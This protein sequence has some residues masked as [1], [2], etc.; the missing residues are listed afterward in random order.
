MMTA[1]VFV[2]ALLLQSA[3]GVPADVPIQAEL[4]KEITSRRSKPGQ[5]VRL[6]TT[7]DVRGPDGAVLIPTGAK[8][9]GKI[10][11]VHKRHGQDQAAIAFVVENAEWKDGSMKLNA[12]LQQ[13]QVVG[14]GGDAGNCGPSLN[15]GGMGACGG[16]SYS[17]KAVPADCKVE[18]VGEGMA[19]VCQKREIELG[20][21]TVVILRNAAT[22]TP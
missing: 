13:V 15:R 8:L 11:V 7:E 4:K 3:A 1:I 2:V 18:Q 14:E 20:P 9:E 5:E 19:F 10:S 12:S 17:V 6:V 21:G 22:A 16:G